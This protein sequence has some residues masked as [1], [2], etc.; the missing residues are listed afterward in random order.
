MLEELKVRNYALVEELSLSFEEGFTILTGET[1]AG[2]SIIVGSLGFLLGAKADADVIRTGADEAG[3]SA[4]VSVREENLDAL[5]WLGTRDISLEDGHIIIRRNIKSSGR[6]AIY[7]QNTLVTRGDLGEFMGLL[8]D[9]HGQHTHES[10]MR[11]EAHRKYLDR[12]ACLEGQTA[13]FNRFFL[14]LA[15]KK[16][17]LEASLSSERDRDTRLEILTHTVE[18]ITRAAPRAGEIRELEAESQRLGDF[19]KL[20]AQV[21]GAAAT[22]YED[23]GSVLSLARRT[24]SALENAAAIDGELAGLAKRME[25]LYYEAEDI[26]EEFRSY[27]QDLK[28]DPERLEEVQERLVLL[29]RLR[30]RYAA[31]FSGVSGASD[32]EA[33]LEYRDR[34]VA[35]IE[36]LSGAEENRDKLKAEIADLEREL[37]SRAAVISAKRNT[38]AGELGSKVTEILSHLGMPSAHFSVSVRS[39]GMGESGL[40]C[41]PWGADDVEFLISANAGEPLREL[42]RIASGGELSR[43]MLAIKTVLSDADT[44][45]TL[46]FDEIDTGIGGEVALSVGEYLAKIGKTKQIFCVTHLATIAVRAD[47]HFKVEKKSYS[48][49]GGEERTVTGVA[50]LDHEERRREIA[51]MLAGDAGAAALAH[52]DELLAKYGMNKA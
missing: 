23:E 44:L 14:A 18:E 45:E 52:A 38:A 7:L 48:Q 47:N 13:E 10:L 50:V 39:K 25:D 29:H 21:N 33:I 37:S 32:E 15:E 2:K 12:F 22:L 8:F 42:N 46:V 40:I 4:V 3:V 16:K 5:D 35:E 43:V 34:A 49:N 27:R 17:T 20:A 30:K 6:G 19:E 51:R 26:S 24:H 36:A 11:R 41:G 1:G 31:S 9:L 28:Y